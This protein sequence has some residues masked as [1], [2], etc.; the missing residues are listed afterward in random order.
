MTLHRC[1]LLL[2]RMQLSFV[3]LTN[4]VIFFKRLPDESFGL[5]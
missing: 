2:G 3:S 5:F 1:D 4:R